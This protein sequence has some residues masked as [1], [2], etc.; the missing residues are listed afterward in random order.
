MILVHHA[1]NVMLHVQHVLVDQTI[2]VLH[3]KAPYIS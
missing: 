1:L 3:A 2:N